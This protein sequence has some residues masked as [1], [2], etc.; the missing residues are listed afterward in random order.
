MLRFPPEEAK[1]RFSTQYIRAPVLYPYRDKSSAR[2]LPIRL[3]MKQYP[4]GDFGYFGSP[5]AS[6]KSA[7]TVC[8]RIHTVEVIGSNPIAPTI[9]HEL[10]ASSDS[11]SNG[12]QGRTSFF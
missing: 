4:C 12:L 7:V 8:G 9:T 10:S 1:R 2:K 5:R 6:V 3:P 11:R